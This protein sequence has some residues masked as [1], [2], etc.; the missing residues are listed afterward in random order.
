[1]QQHVSLAPFLVCSF[2]A[3]LILANVAAFKTQAE[4]NALLP[5]DEK[6]SIWDWTL[7]KF[8][9]LWREHERLCP[10]S[11]WRYLMVLFQVLSFV[12]FGAITLVML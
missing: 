10:G 7:R 8:R 12:L 6:F 1:M 4:V 9:R 3:S 11:R 2:A 5:S